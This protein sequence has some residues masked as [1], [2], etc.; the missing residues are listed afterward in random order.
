MPAGGLPDHTCRK[1]VKPYLPEDSCRRAYAGSWIRRRRVKAQAGRVAESPKSHKKPRERKITEKWTKYAAKQA[2]ATAGCAISKPS[3]W[4]AASYSAKIGPYRAGEN[5]CRTR[6][7]K[8][9]QHG[10]PFCGSRT[11]RDKECQHGEQLCRR[12][13]TNCTSKSPGESH[14]DRTGI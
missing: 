13:S 8:G 5:T 2:F 3:F 6:R 11:R 12:I 14:G 7:D 9:C 4:S 10:E 1:I